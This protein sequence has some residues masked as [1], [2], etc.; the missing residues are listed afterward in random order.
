MRKYG[1][2]YLNIEALKNQNNLKDIK[3]IIYHELLYLIINKNEIEDLYNL[4]LF[5][6][7][8]YNGILGYLKAFIK[9]LIEKYDNKKFSS[10][11]Q[12]MIIDNIYINKN[13]EELNFIEYI[14]NIITK[15]FKFK[16]IIC[17]EGIYF[18]N[19]MKNFFIFNRKIDEDYLFLNELNE[20]VIKIKKNKSKEEL[21]SEEIE[22]LNN[23]NIFELIYCNNLVG[24]TFSSSQFKCLDFIEFIPNYLIVEF[25]G[26]NSK[27]KFTIANQIFSEALNKKLDYYTKMTTLTSIMERDYFPRNVYGISEELLII[28]LLKYNKF[29]ISSFIFKEEN[30][31][32]VQ[33]INNLKNIYLLN[34][35]KGQ[36]NKEDNY[37]ICQ[38]NYYGKNYDLLIVQSFKNTKN[39]IFVQ[40][41]V[42][43]KENDIF[44]QKKDL[45][46]NS[47]NYLECLN[48][49]FGFKIGY[50]S[51]LYIFDEDTQKELNSPKEMSGSKYC[52]KN[53]INFLLYSFNDKA[54]KK[55]NPKDN[56]YYIINGSFYALDYIIYEAKD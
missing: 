20:N 35:F 54:L 37:M 4:R 43:K 21:I 33:E 31:I 53:K 16:V 42:D 27:I 6:D 5:I 18:S 39:A 34:K 28:L 14:I 13:G 24:K 17:G 26:E 29:K 40:I 2:L 51:L 55:Y 36:I 30:I 23:F 38:K 1:S 19:K 15:S 10:I 12:I 3:S 47:Q 48:K 8:Q 7:I 9:N 25:I 32:E 56:I 45:E 49:F 52:L 22:Y 11:N 44:K 41:G 46:D 50:T